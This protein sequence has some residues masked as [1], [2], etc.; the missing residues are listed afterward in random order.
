MRPTPVEKMEAISGIHP[1][2]KR[3]DCKR[4]VQATKFSAMPQHSMRR[5]MAEFSNSRLKRTSFARQSKALLRQHQGSLPSGTQDINPAGSVPPW[6]AMTA[7]VDIKT[8][9]QYLTPGE[10]FSDDCKK[11]LTLSMIDEQYPESSWIQV[12]IDGSATE[13][14]TVRNGGEPGSSFNTPV[15]NSKQ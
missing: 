5:R 9:V 1:L 13:A 12:Y 2:S 4:M 10:A 14:V 11:T 8:T 3:R 6:E 15:D 7:C